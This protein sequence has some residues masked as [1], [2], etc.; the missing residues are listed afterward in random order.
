MRELPESVHGASTTVHTWPAPRDS[1]H[2]NRKG[3]AASV[4]PSAQGWPLLLQ[5][6][7]CHSD[8]PGRI[9][10]LLTMP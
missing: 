3:G 4:M 5:W 1:Q 7:L 6:E 8:T 10:L 2:S 9:I